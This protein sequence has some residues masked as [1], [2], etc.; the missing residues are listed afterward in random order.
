MKDVV[1]VS[2]FFLTKLNKNI[3]AYQ[4][5]IFV[6]WRKNYHRCFCAIVSL[7]HT[8]TFFSKWCTRSLFSIYSLHK[9]NGWNS[10]HNCICDCYEIRLDFIWQPTINLMGNL[11]DFVVVAWNEDKDKDREQQTNETIWIER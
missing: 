7:S 6:C 1:L 4:K 5:G 11:V 3:F 2:K 9:N 8:K 10:I